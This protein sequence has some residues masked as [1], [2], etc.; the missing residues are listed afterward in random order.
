MVIGVIA[1]FFI[2]EIISAFYIGNLFTAEDVNFFE[3]LKA[4]FLC[5]DTKSFYGSF[6]ER[7]LVIGKFVTKKSHHTLFIG[8]R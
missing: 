3:V 8:N 1:R 7:F 2:V 5:V 4:D 6:I